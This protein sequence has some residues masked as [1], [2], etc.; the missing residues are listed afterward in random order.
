MPAA[1]DTAGAP[2]RYSLVAIILHWVIAA[3][4]LA[5]I[6]MGL[7]MDHLSLP[8]M[9]VFKLYQ[10][11]KS[12]GVT[13]MLAVVLRI[14]WRLFHTPPALPATLPEIERKAAHGTHGL[15]YGLQILLPLSGWALVSASV[16][17][18]PTVLYG[19]V[20]WPHL[21]VL[22]SLHDKAPVE[23]ALKTLHHWSAWIL[24]AVIALH[25]AAALRHHVILKDGVLRQMLPT[26]HDAARPSQPA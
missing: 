12:I 3:G 17:N 13:V 7:A 21:P 18:I 8:P 19:V 16:F 2:G 4:I 10:L 24:T 15:L 9:Q 6:G 26:R 1:S 20:P 22:A 11:H 25:V 23:A 14:L 5:L